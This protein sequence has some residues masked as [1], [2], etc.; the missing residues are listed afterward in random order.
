M[1]IPKALTI[2]GSD[3]GGGAGIQADLKTFSAFRVFGMSVITAVTAQNSLGV[4][5]V[6][7]LPPA[8]VALQLRSVL[9]DFGAGA[10]KCGMLSTAPIIEA[11]AA[12]LADD[13]VEKLVVDPVMVATAGSATGVKNSGDVLLQPDARQAL[14]ERVLPLALVVTPNLPEAESLA[15]I[16]V[17]SRPDMEEAARR[18]HRLGPRYVLVKGGHLKGDAIDLLWNGKAFTAFRAPRID[19]GNTHGTGCTLSA[20]IAAGLARGQAIGDAIRDAKAY[21][22][23]AIREGFAAGRGVGQLR[24]FIAEW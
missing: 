11:V 16:P 23:R 8:F 22:T 7:N 13:P 24:H 21:V 12:T 20:A 3:S 17:A 18:I 14:I 10:A 1:L 9:S 6:E 15:G 2:A 4:Q 19:S 5:G